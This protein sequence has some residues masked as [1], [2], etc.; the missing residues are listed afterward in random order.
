MPISGVAPLYVTFTNTSSSD[1]TSWLWQFG[2]GDEATSLS[3]SHTY[4][5]AGVYVV[6]LRATG[7]NGAAVFSD[8]VT[9]GATTAA[10]TQPSPAYGTTPWDDPVVMLRLSNDG[11]KTWI[12]EQMRSAGKYGEYWRRV[13]WNRLGM[14]RRRVF[15][16][17]VADP[18]PWR[19]TGAYLV[20]SPAK[21]PQAAS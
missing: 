4:T 11:G 21:Q 3:P 6:T 16:V 18:I 1:A 9:V 5:T 14:A 20:T 13:R 17:S 12:S 10:Y 2:D 15:E 7:P 19:V 8:I